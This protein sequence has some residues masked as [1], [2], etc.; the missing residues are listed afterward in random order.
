MLVVRKGSF[1]DCCQMFLVDSVAAAAI[2]QAYDLN[3]EPGAL[4]EM[5]KRFP[6][7][8]D[9]ETA[10]LCARTIANWKPF[11]PGRRAR[12]CNV[13]LARRSESARQTADRE[14]T[15]TAHS[16]SLPPGRP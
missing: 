15:A 6:G 14:L 7:I 3:G 12:K 2:R 10:R 8:V 11:E 5:R 4:A 1:L 13:S 16:E 9:D